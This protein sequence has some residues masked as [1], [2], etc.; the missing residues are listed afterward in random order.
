MGAVL[1]S[2]PL[3]PAL[4]LAQPGAAEKQPTA[5]DKETAR[6][7]M[8]QGVDREEAKDFA[9]ALKAYEG[10]HALVRLPM[11]G[12]AVAR[13]Q[14]ALGLY[15][16]ALDTAA[17]VTRMPQRAGEGPAYAKARAEVQALTERLLAKTP[18]VQVTVAGPKEGAEVSID[19]TP[20]PA[21]AASLPHKVNP[22]KH[23]IAASASGYEAVSREVV[24]PEGAAVTPV[25][26]ELKPAGGAG[27][28]SNKN[29][30]GAGSGPAAGGG[31]GGVSPLVYIG[32]G[33]GAAGII[34]GAVTGAISLGQTSTLKD[35]CGKGGACPRDLAG[36][37]DSAN[38]MANV[39]NIS[40]AVGA[41]GAVVGVVGLFLSGGGE[42]AA[43]KA[44]GHI[45]IA[46]AVWPG[47]AGVTGVF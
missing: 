7:L 21:A 19:G 35:E 10:A 2:G 11:T 31:G 26:L 34:A 22:G 29:G 5:A 45:R 41:A 42:K 12:A 3:V 15:V 33:V 43:P 39:S 24:V 23:T 8:D 46:P 4:A 1:A 13:V 16:E 32:F 30:S 47:G 27:G 37:I 36:D 40:F 44:E 9:A 28:V 17:E 18:S 6:S 25:T 38:T 20:L 14:A